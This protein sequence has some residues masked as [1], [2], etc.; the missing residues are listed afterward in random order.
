MNLKSMGQQIM[1]QQIHFGRIHFHPL[2]ELPR[3]AHWSESESK[4]DGIAINLQ[5]RSSLMFIR[6]AMNLTLYHIFLILQIS[7]DFV[8]I[9]NSGKKAVL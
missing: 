7:F 8:S 9:E 3:F 2:S 1:N 5:S 6:L 4:T